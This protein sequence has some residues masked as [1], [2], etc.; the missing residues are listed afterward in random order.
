MTGLLW[1][2]EALP[3]RHIAF[4]IAPRSIAA[5]VA[6]SGF[7]QVVASDAGLW[8]ATYAEVPV[9]KDNDFDRVTCWWAIANL[10]EGRLTP[11]LVP[12]L[13]RY[14]PNQDVAATYG[15]YEDV[16]HSDDAP[17]DDGAEYQGGANSVQLTSGLS[18]RAVSANV[19]VNYGGTIQPG[20]H[21]SIGERLYRVRT[22]VYTTPTTAAITFRP[23]LREPASDGEFL[24]FDEP[25][26]RMRLAEDE[27]MN[28]PLDY[29]YWSF[30]AVNFIEDL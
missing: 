27:G 5:P 7:G 3:P 23:P 15:L 13:R 8:K 9:H 21:F 1:P 19:V 26:C 29:G 28:L 24:D 18:V 2:I 14:Q 16:P 25:V 30:P 12:L 22:A 11:I 4:D 10:L 20:Q 17:F 6:V